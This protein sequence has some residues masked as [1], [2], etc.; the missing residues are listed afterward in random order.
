MRSKEEMM[1]ECKGKLHKLIL[2]QANCESKLYHW[3]VIHKKLLK[4]D[5]AIDEAKKDMTIKKCYYLINELN[6][7]FICI[8]VKDWEKWFG[9]ST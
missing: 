9:D 2:E 4:I 6:E 8:P 3:A 7:K 5:D 1:K